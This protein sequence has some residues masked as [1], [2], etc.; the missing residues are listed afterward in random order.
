MRE[1]AARPGR[2]RGRAPPTQRRRLVERE[3]VLPERRGPRWFAC[4]FVSCRRSTSRPS[5]ASSSRELR[6]S[7]RLRRP[8]RPATF[9]VATRSGRTGRGPGGR[10]V[11]V[12]GTGVRA[13]GRGI[14]GGSGGGGAG[15]IGSRGVAGAC[16]SRW[17]STALSPDTG[18]PLARSSSF[19]CLTVI[20]L[21]S[22][23]LQHAAAGVA[24][25][26]RY[27]PRPGDLA[28]SRRYAR[29]HTHEHLVGRARINP[30]RLQG[31]VGT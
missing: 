17:M 7:S 22:G 11:G 15:T 24:R 8:R 9:H 31:E 13:A 26:E 30:M 25:K 3:S 5:L 21:G 20:W 23:G 27:A 12:C 6:P 2:W 18:K 19:S 28:S 10:G 29:T 14:G 4:S 1:R 16:C